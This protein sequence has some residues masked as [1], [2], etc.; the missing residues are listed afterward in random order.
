MGQLTH[1]RLSYGEITLFVPNFKFLGLYSI[2]RVKC[3][4]LADS[5]PEITHFGL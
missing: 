4:I 3:L 1:I 5:G 2:L